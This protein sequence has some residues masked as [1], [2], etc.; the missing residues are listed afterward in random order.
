MDWIFVL[1]QIAQRLGAGF[2]RNRASF[3]LPAGFVAVM[4]KRSV[5]LG[6]ELGAAALDEIAGFGDDVLQYLDQFLDTGFAINNL[7]S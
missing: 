5:G 7:S 6:N 2:I 3:F 1:L 4:P